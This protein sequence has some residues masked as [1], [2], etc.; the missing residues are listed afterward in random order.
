[1]AAQWLNY[2]HL[3]YFWMIAQEGGVARAAERLRLTHS[4]LS[5]QLRMLEAALE[6]EL[7]E[8]RGRRLVLTPFG[9][10]VAGYAGDI[11]RLGTELVELARSGAHG[12]RTPLKVGVVGT[13]PRSIAHGLL[14]PGLQTEERGPL[15]V[16]QDTLPRLVEELGAGRLHVVLSDALPDAAGVR[17]H[18]R[19]LGETDILLYGT[20][21]LARRYRAGFPASL[22]GAPVLLPGAGSLRR[23]IDRWLAERD[24]RV[25]VEGEID[26]AA[27]L[28]VIGSRGLGLFPVR[29]ALRAEMAEIVG[30]APVGPLQGVR[31]RYYALSLERRIHHP[32]VVAIVERA[33][34]QLLHPDVPPSRRGKR[35]RRA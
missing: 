34:V 20:K 32:A 17:L 15:S 4:T 6:G 30:T 23:A 27:L 1:M 28:R 14:E 9:A 19:L 26:D 18:R 12:R 7:F 11:F 35:P 29:V 31:E 5:A 33:A 3:F 16:R 8:R 21:A 2:H 10:E 22:Q 24:I 25:H 13:M